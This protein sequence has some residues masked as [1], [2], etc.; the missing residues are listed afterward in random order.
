MAFKAKQD[1]SVKRATIQDVARTAGV[2][3]STVSHVLNGTAPISEETKDRVLAA[4]DNLQYYPNITARSLR[5]KRSNMIGLLMQDLTSLF[6]SIAY[7]RL[8]VRAQEN[9]YLMTIMCGHWDFQL[10][11]QNIASLIE[12]QVDGII[13]MGT[14]VSE[15]DLNKASDRGLQVV[16]CDQYSPEF[17]SVEFNNFTTMRR[18]VHCFA[19]DGIRKISYVCTSVR[20][21]DSSEQRYRGYLQGM[22]DE[23]LDPCKLLI[24][25]DIKESKYFRWNKQFD[26]F[27]DFLKATPKE[28]WP[29]VVLC[30]HD[31]IAQAVVYTATREGIK[32]P[33][34]LQV[35]GFDDTNHATLTTPTLSTVKQD[36]EQIADEAFDMLLAMIKGEPHPRHVQLEQ[37]IILRE[38]GNILSDFLEREQLPY[39]IQPNVKEPALYKQ[40]P[41]ACMQV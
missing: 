1:A 12:H 17:A 30:E 24:A 26:R 39:C 11:S 14:A 10:N 2:S 5:K 19:A 32:I 18:L 6:Y 22:Q 7:E 4:V 40:H 27:T 21:Q 29:E 9:G 20:R 41:D 16:L 15:K 34:E 35:F 8:L 23:G 13:A 31:A 28:D 33:E 36:P 38:S 37:Q 25:V 3:A